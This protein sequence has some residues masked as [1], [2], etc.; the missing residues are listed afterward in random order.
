MLCVFRGYLRSHKC[1]H[2]HAALTTSAAKFNVL[3]RTRAV[4]TAEATTRTPPT[5]AAATCRR[6]T[7]ATWRTGSSATT[8]CLCCR[9]GPCRTAPGRPTWECCQ[10]RVCA[11]PFRAVLTAVLARVRWATLCTANFTLQRA[12]FHEVL[13]FSS[14]ISP[15][16]SYMLS[17]PPCFCGRWWLRALL[18]CPRPADAAAVR[19]RCEQF[20]CFRCSFLSSIRA[21]LASQQTRL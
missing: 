7:R 1:K 21:Q 9:A 15:N 10:V 13:L 2:A 6:R 12:S 14:R 11:T 17:K 3:T 20:Q 4:R 5:A 18:Q 19:G 16:P 8:R